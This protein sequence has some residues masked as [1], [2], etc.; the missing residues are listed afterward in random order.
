[1]ISARAIRVE[2]VPI[3]KMATNM[4]TKIVPIEKHTLVFGNVRITTI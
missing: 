1:M 4:L 2:Y 3:A